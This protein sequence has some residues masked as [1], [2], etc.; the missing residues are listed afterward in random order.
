MAYVI[1]SVEDILRCPQFGFEEIGNRV[2]IHAVIDGQKKPL[3]ISL[4]SRTENSG[5]VVERCPDEVKVSLSGKTW[6][7][8]KLHV[9][10]LRDSDRQVMRYV[11]TIARGLY[12]VAKGD[13]A[14]TEW[15]SVVTDNDTLKVKIHPNQTLFSSDNGLN[16]MHMGTGETHTIATNE[17][18]EPEKPPVQAAEK[19][20]SKKRKRGKT[21]DTASLLDG[22]DVNTSNAVDTQKLLSA[23]GPTQQHHYK[24]YDGDQIC[25]I[26]DVGDIWSMLLNGK[27]IRGISLK[28][29]H[30][31]VLSRME[32]EETEPETVHPDMSMFG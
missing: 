4:G 16:W 11:E 19:K 9:K 8:E 20:E 10:L 12:D 14:K 18:S 28:V 32:Q 2:S 25:L 6:E 17:V 13:L 15:F 7:K 30:I 29:R 27:D 31:V 23:L 24:I 3:M 5:V 22:V 1:K 21:V 26:L